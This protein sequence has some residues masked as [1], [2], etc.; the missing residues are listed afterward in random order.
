MHVARNTVRRHQGPHQRTLGFH[1]LH[2]AF[3]HSAGTDDKIEFGA[4]EG[5]SFPIIVII[6]YRHHWTRNDIDEAANEIGGSEFEYRQTIR[7]ESVQFKLSLGIRR[8]RS[9]FLR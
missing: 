9:I 5:L 2:D 1:I 6:L 4:I 8:R 7:S 3:D